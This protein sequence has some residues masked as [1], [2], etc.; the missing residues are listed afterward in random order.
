LLALFV[1]FGAMGCNS[2]STG[3][4]TSTTRNTGTAAGTYTVTVTGIS[5]TIAQAGQISLTVQ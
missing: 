1:C 3:S 4:S 2:V 5:G